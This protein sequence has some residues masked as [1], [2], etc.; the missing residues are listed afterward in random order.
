MPC[1]PFVL[2][3]IWTYVLP[4]SRQVGLIPLRIKTVSVDQHKSRQKQLITPIE[5]TFRM[6]LL[7]FHILAENV[8]ST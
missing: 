2:A 7:T 6:S 4:A 1:I 3:H 5:I 8:S